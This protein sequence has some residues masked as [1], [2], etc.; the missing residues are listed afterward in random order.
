MNTKHGQNLAKCQRF[1]YCQNRA[2]INLTSVVTILMGRPS[3]RARA[4]FFKKEDQSEQDGRVPKIDF[5]IRMD[6]AENTCS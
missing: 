4:A 3:G 1:T 2:K 5:F 6:G